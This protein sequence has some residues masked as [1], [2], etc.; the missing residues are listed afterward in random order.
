MRELQRL[1]NLTQPRYGGP[2]DF[3]AMMRLRHAWGAVIET[4]YDFGFGVKASFCLL[5]AS[6]G[7][8]EWDMWVSFWPH[9]K[10]A[11]QP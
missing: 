8:W 3:D 7:E 10:F 2:I 6:P 4:V 1:H 5:P 9:H 11:W